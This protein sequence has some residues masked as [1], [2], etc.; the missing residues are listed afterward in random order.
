MKAHNALFVLLAL[1]SFTLGT[2]ACSTGAAGPETGQGASDPWTHIQ[3]SGQL[4]VGTSADYPPFE[5][6]NDNFRID[7]FDIA[8]ITEVARS[9]GVSVQVNDIAFEG[10][11][12]AL[13]S[14]QIDVAIAAISITPEREESMTFSQVYYVSEDAV[15]AAEGSSVPGISTVGDLASYTIGVQQSSVFTDWLKDELVDSA[16]MPATNLAIYDEA[17][18]ALRDL[19]DGRID[20]VVM[21]LLPAETALADGG[22]RLVGQGLRRERYGIA[23]QLGAT[24]LRDQINGALNQ[25]QSDGVIANLV[26]EYLSLDGV[27]VIPTPS[28]TP[29]PPTP[30]PDPT[31]TAVPTNTT[32]PNATPAPTDT[33]V[34]PRSRRVPRAAPTAWP[35]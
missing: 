16:A 33:P 17:D 25:L 9:L 24:G 27:E 35:T 5:S 11:P 31:D 18:H 4:V 1:L 12:D 22:V 21:D 28:P 10:L 13:A 14:D 3:Q 6:Y 7:G 19:R 2:L 20:V 15:L 23:M 32:A 29:E 26:N 8:L 30:T 34:P